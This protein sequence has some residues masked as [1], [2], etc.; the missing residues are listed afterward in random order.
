M[1]V[2]ADNRFRLEQI[3]E[4]LN[5]GLIHGNA[6]C[7]YQGRADVLI[8]HQ[9]IND[10]FCQAFAKTIA[11]LSYRITFLLGMDQISLGKDGAAGGNFGRI[12]AVAKGNRT[13]CINTFKIEAFGLLIEKAARSG[14]TGRVGPVT[15]VIALIIKSNETE[16]FTADKQNTAH[17]PVIIFHSGDNGNLSIITRDSAQNFRAGKSHGNT[18]N[19]A[20]IYIIK[21]QAQCFA[22]YATVKLIGRMRDI[23][24][25]VNHNKRNGYRTNIYS[26]YMQHESI[27]SS[28]FIEGNNAVFQRFR[29]L[30]SLEAQLH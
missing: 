4:M 3:A 5:H 12:F 23:S 1:A 16:V 22:D 19:S 29:Q 10:I 6:A 8:R 9:C 13:E 28:I 25:F 7:K 20:Y 17:L 2:L 27:T 14:G 21:H 11:D 30:G 24:L 26:N 15:F 18:A